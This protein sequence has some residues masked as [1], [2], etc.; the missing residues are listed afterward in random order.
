MNQ[1]MTR[2][3]TLT[4]GRKMTTPGAGTVLPIR[5]KVVWE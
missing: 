3:S 5:C 4:F 1:T 2:N